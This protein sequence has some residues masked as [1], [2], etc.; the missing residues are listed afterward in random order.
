[1]TPSSAIVKSLKMST[2]PCKNLAPDVVFLKLRRV[3][4]CTL[5]SG[6]SGIRQ[7][8]LRKIARRGKKKESVVVFEA[9]WSNQQL[10][11]YLFSCTSVHKQT[12]QNYTWD[13][14][15]H[16]LL[17]QFNHL[18]TYVVTQAQAGMTT[19][20]FSPALGRCCE[21]CFEPHSSELSHWQKQRSGEDCFEAIM[22]GNGGNTV[23]MRRWEVEDE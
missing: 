11:C 3:L 6:F 14:S 16:R 13:M 23:A 10:L 5:A 4:K 8:V 22:K 15:H 20:G 7:Y 18:L 12:P 9:P 17:H 19:S 2:S 1:M 21:S